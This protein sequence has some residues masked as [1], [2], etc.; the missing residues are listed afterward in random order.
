M[1][2][3]SKVLRGKDKSYVLADIARFTRDPITKYVSGIKNESA[4]LVSG[5]PA[6]DTY[7]ELPL[8]SSLPEAVFLVR[9]Y[10]TSGLYYKS[11]GTEWL[12]QNGIAILNMNKKRH[13][14]VAP[15]ATFTSL[16]VSSGSTAGAGNSVLINSTTAG[17]HSVGADAVTEG[18]TIQITAGTG[19]NDPTGFYKIIAIP[20]TDTLEVLFPYSGG[21]GVPT[22]TYAGTEVTLRTVNIPPMNL[23]G[24]LTFESTWRVPANANSKRTRIKLGSAEVYNQ[25]HNTIGVESACVI[26]SLKCNGSNTTQIEHSFPKQ[27]AV[28]YGTTS[29]VKP[30]EDI[31][32][33]V[34]SAATF[35]VQPTSAGDVCILEIGVITI[36]Q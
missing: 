13:A 31:D 20:A 25:L 19:W 6:V 3:M 1:F 12:I 28:C 27:I 36:K 35:T 16:A 29:T 22:V 33:S 10:G 34:A 11:T 30:R 2:R 21:L 15:A 8:A 24:E 32:L 23:T 7:G 26:Y 5:N 17:I 18:A 4:E 9:E 14:Y